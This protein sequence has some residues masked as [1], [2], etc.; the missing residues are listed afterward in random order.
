MYNLTHW[1]NPTQ[2]VGGPHWVRALLG[3]PTHSGWF[4][5][6]NPK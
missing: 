6:N 2:W 1:V 4:G 3:N 5:S